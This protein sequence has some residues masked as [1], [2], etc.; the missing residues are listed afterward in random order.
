MDPIKGE[1]F[2]NQTAHLLRLYL[3]ERLIE[4]LAAAKAKPINDIK[5]DLLTATHC[6]LARDPP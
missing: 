1:E 3:V 5:S 4:R 2:L 6:G